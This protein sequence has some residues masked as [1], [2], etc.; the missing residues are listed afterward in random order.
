[1]E[2]WLIYDVATGDVLMRGS[3]SRGT[4]ALQ[5][6]PQ[7]AALAVVPYAVVAQPE[8]DLGALRSACAVGIDAAAESVRLRFLTAGAGQAMTYVRKEAEARA[9]TADNVAETPFLAAEAA[10]RGMTIAALAAEVIAMADQWTTI[11]AAIE[12]LRMGAKAQLLAAPTVGAM[13]A[14]CQVDW[15]AIPI[16]P[17]AAA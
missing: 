12:G 8:L 2:Y 13:V 9:W 10:A 3:G 7:G 16:M 15:S 17:A 11:G 6:P 4:A 5:L 14:A 1:M